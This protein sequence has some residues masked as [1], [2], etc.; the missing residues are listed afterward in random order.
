MH[1]KVIRIFNNLKDI[2]GKTREQVFEHF[3]LEEPN[4]GDV[5][6]YNVDKSTAREKKSIRGVFNYLDT[7]S[8]EMVL[9]DVLESIDRIGLDSFISNF[10]YA[11]RA[12]RAN[13]E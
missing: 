4:D 13:E 5:F 8:T 6:Q 3:A 12:M 9:H 7:L 10:E 11:K 1:P 2:R